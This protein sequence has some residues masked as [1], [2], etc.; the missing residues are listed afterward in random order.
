MWR[1]FFLLLTT[2]CAFDAG[3]LARWKDVANG[4]KRLA[5]YLADAERP[6]QLRLQAAEHLF[7][8]DALDQIMGVV[9]EATPVERKALLKFLTD[10][11]VRV[12]EGGGEGPVKARAASLAYYML[13]YADDLD[14]G[15][16]KK[17]VEPTVAWALVAFG[18]TEAPASRVKPR[19]ILLGAATARAELA[20]PP[21]LAHMRELRRTAATEHALDRASMKAGKAKDAQNHRISYAR[22]LQTILRLSGLLSELRDAD[23]QRLVAHVLLGTA[24]ELYPHLPEALAEAMVANQDETLLRFLLDAV[25]DRRVP[26]G[27]RDVGLR[28]ARELLRG[29]AIDQ[30]LR[31]AGTDDPTVNN[32]PRMSALD[33][34]W[35]FGGVERLEQALRRLPARG[36]WPTDG[37]DFKEEV[38]LFC[39]NRVARAKDPALPVLTRLTADTNW[40]ARIYAIECIARLF[41]GRAPELLQGLEEDETPLRGWSVDGPTTIGD[42]VRD[43]TQG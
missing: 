27:T 16:D 17:L 41:P 12:Y 20:V 15:Y 13:A 23:T 32:V 43:V 40:V 4:P 26:S 33:L 25:R 18:S 19:S 35:D 38:D 3:D 34:L 8:K 29:K 30:L 7:V 5:G 2:G 37:A 28:V 31:L 22:D 39:D 1:W 10:F 36:T 21:V 42:V 9:K 24:R 6:L 11:V 14:L